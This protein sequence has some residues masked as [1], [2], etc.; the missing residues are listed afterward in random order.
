MSTNVWEVHVT[1]IFKTEVE[2]GNIMFLC[3]SGNHLLL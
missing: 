2:D 3:N 1:F